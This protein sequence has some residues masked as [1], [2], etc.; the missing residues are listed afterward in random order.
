MGIKSLVAINGIVTRMQPDSIDWSRPHYG[1]TGNGK[2]VEGPYYTC[3]LGFSRKSLVQ[4]EE[5]FRWKGQEI[6]MHLPHVKTGITTEFTDVIIH[7]IEQAM[8]IRS[9]SFAASDGV[10]IT[11]IKIDMD[12]D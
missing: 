8:D 7:R 9:S 1:N 2:P 3:T 12:V 5:W 4:F 10:D 6:D 11:I